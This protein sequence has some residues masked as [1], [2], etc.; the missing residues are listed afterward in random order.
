MPRKTKRATPTYLERAALYYLQRYGGSEARLRR[1][2]RDRVRRSVA[3][4][5]TDP[6]EGAAAIDAVVLKLT[7]LGYIDDGRLAKA[8][9]A[10]LRGRGKSARAIRA[11]MRQHG[12]DASHFEEAL[13]ECDDLAAARRMVDKRRLGAHRPE[14]E[15]ASLRQRDLAR[16]ARAGFSYDVARRALDAR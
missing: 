12:I 8:K 11:A 3:E 1:I 9:V 14:E 4:H 7:R 2:L 5:D 13:E 15:R 16:L 10:T 6:D